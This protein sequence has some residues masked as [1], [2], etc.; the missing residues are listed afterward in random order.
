MRNIS[1][2]WKINNHTKESTLFLACKKAFSFIKK[3]LINKFKDAKELK[4]HL[5]LSNTMF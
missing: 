1:S 5:N 2:Y 3:E 4:K